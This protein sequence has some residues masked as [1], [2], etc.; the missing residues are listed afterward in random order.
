MSVLAKLR[1]AFNIIVGARNAL[2]DKGETVTHD[3]D[4][5]DVIENMSSGGLDFSEDYTVEDTTLT[6]ASISRGEVV[7]TIPSGVTTI[8]KNIFEGNSI[9]EKF[10][11]PSSLQTIS[12]GAFSWCH[13]LK[14]IDL[15]NTQMTR[16]EPYVFVECEK[17]E[18]VILPNGLTKIANDSNNR[19]RQFQ[20]CVNLKTLSLPD[21][22]QYISEGLC[23]GCSSLK[24]VHL[25]TALVILRGDAF[26]SCSSLE[27]INIPA[28]ITTITQR[29]YF[30]FFGLTALKN[31]TIENGFNCNNLNLS[32][33][34]LYS[35]DT[36]LSWL[37]ALYDR[38]GLTAYTLTIGTTNLN[39]MTA[40]EI[41][42]A[43]NKNWNLA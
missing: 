42:I 9:V 43:T 24:T 18:T 29:N 1:Q 2:I 14:T 40:E 21:T 32:A 30:S 3:D 39:K 16:L 35:H 38:T 31:V 4:I 41:G 7:A 5:P 22:V 26:T 17:L 25:S 33:S 34:T 12:N 6:G 20:N 37:N 10:V 11:F 15:S 23:A 27:T 28:S 36:I 19:G 8:S 13:A